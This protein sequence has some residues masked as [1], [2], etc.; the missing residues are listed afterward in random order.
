MVFTQTIKY[1]IIASFIKCI[2]LPE[3]KVL[4]VR[5]RLERKIQHGIVP[6]G[7][8]EDGKNTYNERHLRFLSNLVISNLT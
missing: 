1:A 8:H 5:I 4:S 3:K 7:I 2:T 6:F